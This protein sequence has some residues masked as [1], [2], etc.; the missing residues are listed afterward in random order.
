MWFKGDYRG[1][2]RE[3]VKREEKGKGGERS[4]LWRDTRDLGCDALSL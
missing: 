3:I 1:L 4:V 2:R